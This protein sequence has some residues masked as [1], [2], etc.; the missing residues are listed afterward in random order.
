MALTVFLMQARD[1]AYRDGFLDYVRDAYRGR[2]KLGTGR[3]LEDRLD[4]PLKALEAQFREFLR[5][6]GARTSG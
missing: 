6:S 3:S 2:I 4:Q 5:S 1:A